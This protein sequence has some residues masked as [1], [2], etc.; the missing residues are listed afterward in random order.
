MYEFLLLDMDDTI[1]DFKKAEYVALRKTLKS[2]GL[3][4]TDAV[5]ARY[6]Q[7]NQ[8]YWEMLERKEVTRE[9]L[10]LGRFRDLFA[11]YGL[12]VDSLQCADRY[13]ENLA[14]THDFLPGAEE[15][16]A[17][18]SPKYKLYLVSNGTTYVQAK[19]IENS[20]IAKYCKEIFISE[21]VGVDKPDKVF[22]DRCFAKIPG[23]CKEKAIIVGDSLTS[24]IQGGI[25]AG[26]ATC[27]VNPNH[28]P[29]RADIP[30]D[31]QIESLTQLEALLETL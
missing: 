31:Y 26:I 17:S 1:L 21:Q 6:S 13:I 3:E 12:T 5:C 7:I 9:A 30:A 15:A 16:L 18:L 2:F 19:R 24:D 11:E 4:P 29:A 14:E 8:H 23:F 20:G 10:K 27:W 28:K 25:N 22:F